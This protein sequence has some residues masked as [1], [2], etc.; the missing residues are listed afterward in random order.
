MSPVPAQPDPAPDVDRHDDDPAAWSA[1]VLA[2]I[3]SRY[4]VAPKRLAA[5]G[6]SAEQLGQLVEAAATAPDHR[7]LQPWRLVRVQDH[8]RDTLADLFEA[9]A[10]DRVPLPPPEDL[11]LARDKAHRAPTLLLAVLKTL[12]EDPEVPPTERA[13]ALGAGLMALMLAAHGMGFGAMLTSGRAVRTDRF[14]RAFALGPGEQ[15]IT[16]V[17][18]GT[19]QSPRRKP[20]S[21]AEAWLSDWAP[22]PL[23]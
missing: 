16:F 11:A 22:P 15:A 8:Q 5:P 10:R 23:G 17:S 21:T 3:G 14:A 2:L 7:G 4:S 13:V 9:C 19:P 6:P 12:P 20:R 1:L 18:I